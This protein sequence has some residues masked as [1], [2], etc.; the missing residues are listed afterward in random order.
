[1]RRRLLMISLLTVSLALGRTTWASSSFPFVHRQAVFLV[2]QGHQ[3]RVMEFLT[4]QGTEPRGWRI[5]LPTG[6]RSLAVR[7][8]DTTVRA[9]PDYLVLPGKAGQAFLTFDLPV[10]S[11]QARWIQRVYDP[12]ETFYLLTGP[13]VKLPLVLNQLFYQTK[14]PTEVLD[15]VVFSSFYSRPLAPGAAF[16]VNLELARHLPRASLPPEDRIAGR[17]LLGL[18]LL[19]ALG[20]I[21]GAVFLHRRGLP[22]A[23]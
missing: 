12:T 11:Y 15:G 13:G 3:L 4:F 1:M 10:S 18:S 5:S 14:P 20:G 6:Y 9:G 21:A 16:R 23:A 2:A 8:A 7:R 22:D 19:A 17:V